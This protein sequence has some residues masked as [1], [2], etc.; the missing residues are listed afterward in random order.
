MAK[1]EKAK[2]LLIEIK[3]KINRGHFLIL[4]HAIARQAQRLISIPDIIQVLI[5]G[6]HE[7]KN[8]KY[9][10]EFEEWNY[11]IRGKTVDNRVLRI[12]TSFNEKNILV[13]TVID[14]KRKKL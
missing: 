9:S 8:D 11:A 6:W 12:I 4:P 1:K 7:T 13:I 2:N 14:L 3:A 10:K 5:T